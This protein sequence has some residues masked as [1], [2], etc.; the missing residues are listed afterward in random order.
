MKK[1]ELKFT[2][3]LQ[4]KRDAVVERERIKMS[5]LINYNVILLMLFMFLLLLLILLL[6]DIQ[7]NSKMHKYHPYMNLNIILSLFNLNGYIMSKIECKDI[8]CIW[9]EYNI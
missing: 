3:K 2:Q 1:N 7:H 9:N 4:T 6:I 5:Q 8:R